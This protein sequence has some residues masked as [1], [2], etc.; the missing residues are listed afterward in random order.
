MRKSW[1][2]VLLTTVMVC[3][4]CLT[5]YG[6]YEVP[7]TQ[8]V[9]TGIRQNI[10]DGTDKDD[11]GD[12]PSGGIATA[13]NA[14]AL[15]LKAAEARDYSEVDV[16]TFQKILADHPELEELVDYD[17][18]GTWE[19]AGLVEWD[20]SV[21]DGKFYIYEMNLESKNLNGSL[22]VS[23]LTDLWA[24]HVDNNNLEA[25]RLNNL[26]WL[27]VVDGMYT[28]DNLSEFVASSVPGVSRLELHE[29]KKLKKLELSGMPGL[30]ILYCN[31]TA[32]SELDLS[33]VPNLI[34]LHCY[35]TE[36]SELD[37]SVVP[38]L[39]SLSC[40]RTEISELDLFRVPNLESL[41]CGKTKIR[42]LDLS[43]VPDL[44]VL[45]CWENEISELDLSKVPNLESLNCNKTKISELDLSRVPNLKRL[46]CSETEISELDLSGMSK[47]EELD[48]SGSKISE[49]ELSVVPDLKKLTCDN[50]NMSE[51]NLSG[52]PGLTSLRCVGSNIS[53]LEL[54]DMPGNLS[55]ITCSDNNLTKL[56]LPAM[57]KLTYLYCGGNQLT[58]LDL[59]GAP[60]LETLYCAWNN[61]ETLN[62]SGLEHLNDL[63]CGFV[64][65]DLEC[66][67]ITTFTSVDGNTLTVKAENGGKAIM[68]T[69]EL[70]KNE[71]VIEA[72]PDPGYKFKKW[73]PSVD[74]GNFVLSRVK[75]EKS[76]ELTATF[77]KDDTPADDGNDGN[78]EGG[79]SDNGSGNNSGN[80]NS[81]DGSY[82][83]SSPAKE[84]TEIYTVGVQGNW[85]LLD[86]KTHKW[87]FVK[88]DGNYI[89]ARW[90]RLAY[91]FGGVTNTYWYYFAPDGIM[92]DGW[93]QDGN[94][95]WYYLSTKHDGWFGHAL[96][97]WYYDEPSKHW[98]Y[99]DDTGAMV[100]GWRTIDGKSYYFHESYAAK[101]G[102]KPY[103]SMYA[104]EKTPDGYTVDRNGVWV[105]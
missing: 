12:E 10:T 83:S 104:G 26:P 55:N 99:L 30:E 69:Y 78:D 65:E 11:A 85:K 54:P 57:P 100:T 61:L 93:F 7:L 88:N 18:P 21:V 24:L 20:D 1:I 16:E 36:I 74:S 92:A 62:I 58:E 66:N 77:K 79:G 53:K 71:A 34:N 14:D 84:D 22:E 73:L 23:G 25:I 6:A 76:K 95:K 60:N 35:G 67:R 33:G 72:Y 86:A 32:I 47:L 2:G 41:N 17:D 68:S 81:D 103:G 63:R 97:G 75:L 38:N 40:Y 39:E 45:D 52:V 70:D 91:T 51:L 49:L 64:R 3:G 98:Y 59:S 4:P 105:K 56:E 46:I 5:S 102:D 94:G 42:E 50:L 9:E 101:A 31:Y 19:E 80:N 43:V 8:G 87:S 82:N 27:E 90:G 96:T 28:N 37:L 44:K 48:C 29:R 15:F 13:S 89:A